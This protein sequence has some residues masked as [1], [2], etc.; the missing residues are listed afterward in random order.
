MEENSLEDSYEQVEQ[1]YVGKEQVNAKHGDGE[2]LREGWGLVFIQHRT[3]GLQTIR[4][5]HA[6][7]VYIK[8]S[9]C[10]GQTECFTSDLLWLHNSFTSQNC[11]V[12]TTKKVIPFL[13][14]LTVNICGKIPKYDAVRLINC[15]AKNPVQ[16]IVIVDEDAL[17]GH[18]VRHHPDTQQ[19]HEEEHIH[20]LEDKNVDISEYN[21]QFPVAPALISAQIMMGSLKKKTWME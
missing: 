17:F 20:H 14:S 18:A 6:A 12:S 19:E 9:I 8:R 15:P 10:T 2:P 3:L 16:P 4:A 21:N 1:Q 11:S 13:T 7:G 5:I